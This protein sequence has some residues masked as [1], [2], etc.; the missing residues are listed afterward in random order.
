ME[1]TGSAGFLLAVVEIITIN[2]LLSGGKA[3]GGCQGGG[4]MEEAFPAGFW[5][6]L[7]EITTTNIVLGGDNALVIALA[8]RGLPRGARRWGI[9]FGTVAAIVLRIIFAIVIV[10]LLRI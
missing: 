3:L 9:A 1:E 8:C 2:I 6:A 10:F 4:K 7:L 5:L